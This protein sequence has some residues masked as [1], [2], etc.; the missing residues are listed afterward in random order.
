MPTRCASGINLQ[1]K[2]RGLIASNTGN[3]AGMSTKLW[4]REACLVLSLIARESNSRARSDHFDYQA[5]FR[6]LARLARWFTNTVQAIRMTRK[7]ARPPASDQI[8]QRVTN[9]S[10]IKLWEA[11]Q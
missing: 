2:T 4:Q 1:T 11:R 3:S 9:G 7:D 5:C 10:R 8:T 6:T